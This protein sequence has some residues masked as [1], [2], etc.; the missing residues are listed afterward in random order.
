MNKSPT[1]KPPTNWF[2]FQ[3][4]LVPCMWWMVFWLRDWP[5]AAIAA[6]MSVLLVHDAWKRFAKRKGARDGINSD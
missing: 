3:V 4:A 1:E 6:V 5:L 2:P